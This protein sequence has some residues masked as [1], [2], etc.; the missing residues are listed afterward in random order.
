V[1][2]TPGCLTATALWLANSLAFKWYVLHFGAYQ[3]AYGA[4]GGVRVALLWL[5]FSG[6][7]ILLGAHAERDDR[8]GVAAGPAGAVTGVPPRWA[9]SR[10]VQRRL[11]RSHSLK[12]SIGKV[13]SANGANR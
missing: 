3:K 4:I 9:L 6:L 1:W 5:Y 8:S 11:S 10:R 2:I 12:N 7:A 13:R